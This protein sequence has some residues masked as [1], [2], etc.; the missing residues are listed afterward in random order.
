MQ[1]KLPVRKYV[2]FLGIYRHF[3]TVKWSTGA[4]WMCM[5]V[6]KYHVGVTATL[7]RF[8]PEEPPWIRWAVVSFGFGLS[9]GFFWGFLIRSFFR[10]FIST[11][12]SFSASSA[13]IWLYFTRSE[14]RSDTYVVVFMIRLHTTAGNE[15]RE[16]GSSSGKKTTRKNV[17][18]S[19]FKCSFKTITCLRSASLLCLC[20][21]T[22]FYEDTCVK[23][24][25]FTGPCLVSLR[26]LHHFSQC[27][28][29]VECGW[30]IAAGKQDILIKTHTLVYM[31]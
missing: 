19:P 13:I 3:N 12:P 29:W 31:V 2:W 22:C 1:M 28:L 18:F 24:L 4:F 25:H 15:T 11:I 26:S 14:L 20:W 10:H 6:V 8:C 5:I 27:F 21:N 23:T 7:F 16:E 9:S 17:I 30:K